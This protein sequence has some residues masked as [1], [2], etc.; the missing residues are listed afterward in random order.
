MGCCS[1]A[2]GGEG[3]VGKKAYDA[4]GGCGWMV[5]RGVVGEAAVDALL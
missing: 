5:E 2:E 1:A 4:A 3:A